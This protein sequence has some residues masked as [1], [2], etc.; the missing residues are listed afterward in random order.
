MAR[1]TLK[2]R[3]LL[4]L[5][6]YVALLSAMLAVS[7]HVV[8]EHAEHLVWR[9]L[10]E[11]EI[12]NVVARTASQ[13]DY[14]WQDSDTLS[15]YH[16]DAASAT[17]PAAL[18][19]LPPGLHDDIRVAGRE[20]VVL[21]RDTPSLGRLA[22]VLD[23]TDFEALEWFV[24][25]WAVVA[26][27]VIAV[28]TFFMASFG[29][30]RIVR[31][32]TTLA[33]HI[34]ALRPE[35][36]GERVEVGPH[37]SSEME[38]ITRAVNDYVRRNEQFVE[39][40]RAFIHSASHELRT[41]V[42]VIAGAAEL[43]LDQEGVPQSAREQMQRV[44]RTAQGVEQLIALL[45]VLARDPARLAMINDRVDLDLL[46]PEIVDDHRHL[47][48]DKD[49]ELRVDALS[50]C[51]LVAPLAIVQA[52]IG[53]L[54]RN[55]IENSDRGEISIALQPHGVVVI[56]DPGHGMSPEE[57]SA[58]YARMARG[59]GRGGNGI[60]LDLIAR[61]CEHLGWTLRIEPRTPRGTRVTLDFGPALA[62]A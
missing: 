14:R 41:P 34:G 4:W 52:A 42:V 54:L 9:A 15:L 3:I 61:L 8:H 23:I 56:E 11:S 26:G 39:R 44:R 33:T 62:G 28:V 18:D 6:S 53:N 32:L 36:P 22:M 43:A 35:T 38:V 59:G 25:R 12:D 30:E 45:L 5:V 2:R 31:P 27:L 21:V 47:C 7:G 57:I 17:E 50:P 60:G 19:T 49:L 1:V 10:L 24:W 20:S 29:M 46:L 37:A 58:V 16:L 13:P 48:A 51:E 55:A 40:E